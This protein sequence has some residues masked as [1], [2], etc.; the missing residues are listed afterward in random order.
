[1][2]ISVAGMIDFPV[3]Y[4]PEVSKAAHVIGTVLGHPPE[5]GGT[6]MLLLETQCT[7]VVGYREIMAEL[8]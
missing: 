7:L 4:S 6:R 3:S 5:L 1:M 2:E 8:P